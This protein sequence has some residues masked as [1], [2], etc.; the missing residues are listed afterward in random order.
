MKCYT[1]FYKVMS[2]MQKQKAKELIKLI[3][4]DMGINIDWI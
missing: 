1:A 4:E 2:N 3:G